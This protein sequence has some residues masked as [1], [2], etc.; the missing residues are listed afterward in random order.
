M[1]LEGKELEKIFLF[2][3]KWIIEYRSTD[4]TVDV[5]VYFLILFILLDQGVF[6]FIYFLLKEYIQINKF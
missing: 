6:G 1:K 2:W 3:E 4:S 5:T